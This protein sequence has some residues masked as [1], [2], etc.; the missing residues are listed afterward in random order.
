M[1]WLFVSSSLISTVTFSPLTINRWRDRSRDLTQFRWYHLTR[2][3]KN[4]HKWWCLSRIRSSKKCVSSSKA[5]ST[6]SSSYSMDV[7]FYVV[8]EVK[9]NN[10]GNVIYVDTS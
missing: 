3:L 9:V 6:T 5:T 2:F 1:I 7:I 8:R 4:F 10:V